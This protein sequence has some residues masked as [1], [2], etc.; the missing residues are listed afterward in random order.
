M[1]E[2][3]E[4]G[5]EDLVAVARVVRPRGL[6][7]EVVANVLTDFPE[8][9]VGL[10]NVIALMPDG[11]RDELKIDNHWFQ[12]DRVIL[13]FAD[14]DGIDA[15]EKF[16]NAEICVA[17]SEAVELGQDEYFDWQL[18]GCNVVMVEGQEIGKVDEVM[19]T[20]GT[21]NLLVKNAEK[22]FLI[23]F[24]SEIC[25]EVDIENKVIRI[26]PPEGLLEF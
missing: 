1:A 3:T 22:D 21:E 11:E 15:V 9:F 20:G 18:I 13:K 26:D 17:E 4:S 8:R 5:N 12:K 2:L 19:R 23:P 6:K 10:E 16:R 14:H 7:G 25:I 24:A